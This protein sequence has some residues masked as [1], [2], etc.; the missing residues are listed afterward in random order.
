[1]HYQKVPHEE[2]K[3]VRCVRGALFDVII[4]LRPASPICLKWAGF[5][6]SA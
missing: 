4:D 1:M 5:G 2:A 3:F 6:I